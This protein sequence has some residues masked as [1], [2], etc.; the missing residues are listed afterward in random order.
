MQ[1]WRAGPERGTNL[2]IPSSLRHKRRSPN[3]TRSGDAQND[4][5][6]KAP[7]RCS[8]RPMTSVELRCLCAVL[9]AKDVSRRQRCSLCPSVNSQFYVEPAQLRLDRV[10]ADEEMLGHLSVC[11]ARR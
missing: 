10:H 2:L 3:F 11:H 8:L 7:G 4:F 6:G 1:E 5:G 9:V